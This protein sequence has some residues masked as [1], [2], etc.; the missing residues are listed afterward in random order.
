M[1]EHPKALMEVEYLRIVRI[2][3]RSQVATCTV[4]GLARNCYVIG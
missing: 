3:K 2:L 1:L 4:G